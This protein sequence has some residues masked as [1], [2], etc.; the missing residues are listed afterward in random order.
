VAALKRLRRRFA[1]VALSNADLDE[2]VALSAYGGLAWHAA[3]SA[4]GTRNYKPPAS[5]YTST[6]TQ[7]RADPQHTLMVAAHPWDLRAAAEHGY[8]T[9]YI[10]RPGADRPADGEHF[11]R[12]RRGSGGA[13]RRA[14]AHRLT[15]TC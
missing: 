12:V 4:E 6:L 10:A 2:L 11:R 8:V 5:V 1:V 9:A 15:R 3:L 13:G 14:A 7:L